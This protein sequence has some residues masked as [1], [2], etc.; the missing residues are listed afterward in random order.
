MKNKLILAI[1]TIF[2]VGS[3][4]SITALSTLQEDPKKT[5]TAAVG[6]EIQKKDPE[7]LKFTI[8]PAYDNGVRNNAKTMMYDV[9]ITCPDGTPYKK[10]V[11]LRTNNTFYDSKNNRIH[12]NYNK[13]A[14]TD[15]DGVATIELPNKNADDYIISGSLDTSSIRGNTKGYLGFET[16]YNFLDDFGNPLDEVEITETKYIVVPDYRM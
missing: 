16:K 2:I 13:K 1:L 4:A 5:T 14:V 12:E 7:P 11:V 10:G 15:E 6:N 3:I 8:S 9:T